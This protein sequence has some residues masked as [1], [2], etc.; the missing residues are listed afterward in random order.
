[1]SAAQLT[2]KGSEGKRAAE[3]PFPPVPLGNNA[4]FTST[5]TGAT[6]CETPANGVDIHFVLPPPA[7]V[8]AWYLRSAARD[9][10][11]RNAVTVTRHGEEGMPRLRW[12]G[13]RIR[14]GLDGVNVY[15]RPDR[16][17]GRVWGV[18]ICGQSMVC[19]VCAPRIAAFRAGEVTECFT[20]SQKAG[21]E[22]RLNTYTVPHALGDGLGR[23]VDCFGVAWANYM[24]GREAVTTRRR[25]L[26]YHC[27]REATWSER[28]GWH[29]HHHVLRYDEPD[30]FSEERERARWLAALESVGRRWRGAELH[31]FD[32]GVVGSE[33]GASY[34][35]KLATAVDAQAR[36]IGSEIASASTKG[37]NFATLLLQ[38]VNGDAAAEKVWADGVRDI[39]R[40]K[41]SS[42]RWSR[43]LRERVGLSAEK[44]DAEVAQEETTETDVFLGSLTASQWR[45]VLYWKAE[46]ALLCA[47]NRGLDAVNDFLTGLSLGRLN[48]DPPP[49]GVQYSKE[50][51]EEK[52]Q[53]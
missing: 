46:F 23:E 18:C 29:Y 21:Y 43:G 47:A 6:T 8:K 20:R 4:D 15:S 31:A 36:A 16:A 25:S 27:G 28:N 5:P 12:C 26:G 51:Y 42:V 1:M 22:A 9:L 3:R 41:V 40:R 13:S 10:L 49:S 11:H 24:S 30:T 53:C 32:S 45:G 7:T 48:D 2:A 52:S 38:A 17:Y 44:T 19:P 50:E 14:R 37:R 39:V 33:A 34:V 35:S